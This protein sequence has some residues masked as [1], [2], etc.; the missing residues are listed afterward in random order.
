MHLIRVNVLLNTWKEK[1]L[2]E[3]KAICSMSPNKCGDVPKRN[4]VNIKKNIYI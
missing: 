2:F 4:R 3:H 1:N